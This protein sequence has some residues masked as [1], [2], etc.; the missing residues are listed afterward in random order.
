[1]SNST[2]SN[3]TLE[4]LQ[5]RMLKI[6]LPILHLLIFAI[7]LPLNSFCLW[8]LS[9]HSRPW[10][11]TVIFAINLA[12]ADLLYSVMLPFQAAYHLQGNNWPFGSLLCRI[13]TVLF[14]GNMEC[15]ILTMTSISIERYLGIVHPLRSQRLRTNRMAVWTCLCIWGGILLG[16]YPF[17]SNDLTFPVQ[18]LGIV[19]C[20]DILPKRM[21]PAPWHFAL[22]FGFHVFLT[23]P[24]PLLVMGFCYGSVIRTLLRSSSSVSGDTRRQA[25]SLIVVVLVV[26]VLCYLPNSIITVLHLVYMQKYKSAYVEYKLSL[27]VNSLNACIDPFLYYFGS[28]EFRQKMRPI[29]GRIGT[30]CRK[31]AAPAYLEQRVIFNI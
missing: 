26:F 6:T 23:F 5:N 29:W 25:V 31:Q 28:R 20:F 13:L 3:G 7:S 27:A 30:C 14:Y 12:V 2:L 17:M 9:C 24:L 10:V 18:E 1:M 19:T 21:F 16:N 11:P 15:S 22:F 8:I 4:M